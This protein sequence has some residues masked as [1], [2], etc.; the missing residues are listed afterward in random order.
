MASNNHELLARIDERVKTIFNVVNEFRD[1]MET[2]NGR[3]GAIEK[4][5]ARI[6]GGVAVLTFVCAVIGGKLIFF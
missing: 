5:K 1:D 6:T 3:V 4:W 2:L